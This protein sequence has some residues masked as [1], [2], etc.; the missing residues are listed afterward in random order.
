M[1][2]SSDPST[3]DAARAAFR[4]GFQRSAKGNLWRR[5]DD[6]RAVTVFRYKGGGFAW[7]VGS[8]RDD[9]GDARF[10]PRRYDTERAALAALWD[11]LAHE[12]T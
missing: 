12:A 9:P 8:M 1:W 5:L 2:R 3:A 10:S 11:E 4:A 7:A 6:G